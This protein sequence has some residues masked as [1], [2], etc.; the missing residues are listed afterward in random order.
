MGLK[1][2]KVR[3]L[4]GTEVVGSVKPEAVFGVPKVKDMLAVDKRLHC[5]LNLQTSLLINDS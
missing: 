5:V 2:D 4:P 3:Y 1:I